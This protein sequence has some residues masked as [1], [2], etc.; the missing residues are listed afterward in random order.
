MLPSCVIVGNY[1]DTPGVG[2]LLQQHL[3]LQLPLE[4]QVQLMN[5]RYSGRNFAGPD[6]EL[7]VLKNS[8]RILS[9]MAYSASE[10]NRIWRYLDDVMGVPASTIQVSENST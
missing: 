1:Y 7:H 9:L 8:P 4:N 3:R 5:V 2:K 10:L 6:R